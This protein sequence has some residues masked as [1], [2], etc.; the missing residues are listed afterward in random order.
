MG[1]DLMPCGFGR[2]FVR[3]ILKF[4]DGFFNFM[5]GVM[6]AA[7]SHNWQRVGDMAARTVVVDVRTDKNKKNIYEANV[8]GIP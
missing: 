1:T 6:V 4:V 8:N 5:V 2:A 3:N 7:L